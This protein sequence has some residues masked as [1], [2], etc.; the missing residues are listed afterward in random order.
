MTR[1]HKGTSGEGG[2]SGP[3]GRAISRRK[4][5]LREANFSPT[6]KLRAKIERLKNNGG[7]WSP[8]CSLEADLADLKRLSSTREE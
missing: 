5:K 6:E 3:G 8:Y 7:Y 1:R 4:R 2:F